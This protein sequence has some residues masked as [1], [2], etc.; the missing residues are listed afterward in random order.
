MTGEGGVTAPKAAN[1]EW[2]FS[3]IE[4]DT[5]LEEDASA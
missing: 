1:Q 2:V 4:E 5:G 3:V